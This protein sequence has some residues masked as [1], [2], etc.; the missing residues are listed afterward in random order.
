[1]TDGVDLV[2]HLVTLVASVGGAVAGVK[3]H[4]MWIKETLERHEKAIG[5]AFQEIKEVGKRG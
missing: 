5:R 2:P 3:I 1:M 4:I